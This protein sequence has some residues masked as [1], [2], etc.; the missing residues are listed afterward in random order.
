MQP[1]SSPVLTGRMGGRARY[2]R[3]EQMNDPESF[4]GGAAFLRWRRNKRLGVVFALD[5]LGD[6]VDDRLR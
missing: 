6:A 4:I 2:E 1:S 3:R 5:I